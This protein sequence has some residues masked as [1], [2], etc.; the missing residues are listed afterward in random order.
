M[1]QH[2]ILVVARSNKPIANRER[3]APKLHLFDFVAVGA[4]GRAFGNPP[5]GWFR[6]FPPIGLGLGDRHKRPVG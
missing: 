3:L 1:G 6:D 4:L 2:P 5:V